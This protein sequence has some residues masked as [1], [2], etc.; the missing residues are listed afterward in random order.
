MT[1]LQRSLSRSPSGSIFCRM[2]SMTS[3]CLLQVS[4]F[5]LDAQTRPPVSKLRYSHRTSD[6][7]KNQADASS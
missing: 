3:F 5:A 4:D 2:F 1:V 6:I 7:R